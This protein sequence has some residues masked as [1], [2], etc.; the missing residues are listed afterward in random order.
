MMVL[1]KTEF[2]ERRKEVP[3]YRQLMGYAK[4]IQN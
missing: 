4:W 2:H 3:T 1:W